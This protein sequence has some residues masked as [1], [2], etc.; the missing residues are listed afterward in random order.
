MSPDNEQLLLLKDKM[1]DDLEER[2]RVKELIIERVGN[3]TSSLRDDVAI[4]ILPTMLD[5]KDLTYSMA[6]NEA[7]RIA[8]MFL[9]IKE[10]GSASTEPMIEELK[11]M[12]EQYPNDEKLGELIRD[13]VEG[14]EV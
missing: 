1:I 12:V 14:G 10:S 2:L 11:K 4:S 7:F 8:D 9:R 6:I 3:F 5:I 13:M